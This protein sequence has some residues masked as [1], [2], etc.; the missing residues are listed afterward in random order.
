MPIF[1]Y[2]CNECNQ[3]FENIEVWTSHKATKCVYCG[4]KKIDKIIGSK[5][6]IRP[7]SDSILKSMPDPIPPLTELIGKNKPGYEGGYKELENGPRELKE[8][9]RT[10]DKYGNANWLPKEKTYFDMG[11]KK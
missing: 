5:I 10:R 4:S 1:D 6:S 9:K 2:H 3:I 8:Y 7:D 11:K